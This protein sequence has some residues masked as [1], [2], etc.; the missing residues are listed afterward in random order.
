MLKMSLG[1]TTKNVAKCEPFIP[2]PSALSMFGFPPPL[3]RYLCSNEDLVLSAISLSSRLVEFIKVNVCDAYCSCMYQIF[4]D[5]LN[6]QQIF[7]H[8]NI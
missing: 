1:P 4:L 8:D 6:K 3:C 2:P 5:I 7:T